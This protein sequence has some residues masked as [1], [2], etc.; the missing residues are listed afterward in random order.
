M[1]TWKYTFLFVQNILY[2]APYTQYCWPGSIMSVMDPDPACRYQLTTDYAK[3]PNPVWQLTNINGTLLHLIIIFF[4]WQLWEG[5][6]HSRTGQPLKWQ[7]IHEGTTM[8][9]QPE[10]QDSHDRIAV[11]WQ[12][13]QTWMTGHSS[14]T[15]L[16][17]QMGSPPPLRKPW[18]ADGDNFSH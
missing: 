9:D 8:S 17:G 15:T 4:A 2:T 3:N 5:E 14:R 11:T 16:T 6:G 1:G 10:T 7:R 18:K 13:Q 12:P